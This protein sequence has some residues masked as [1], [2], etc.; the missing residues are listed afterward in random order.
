MTFLKVVLLK[1]KNKSSNYWI[2]AGLRIFVRLLGTLT[3]IY[4]L[5][6]IDKLFNFNSKNL[7][8][9]LSTT[10]YLLFFVFLDWYIKTSLNNDLRNNALR[11]LNILKWIPFGFA[12]VLVYLSFQFNS[13]SWSQKIVENIIYSYTKVWSIVFIPNLSF[14]IITI[15]IF[16]T[17]AILSRNK[18]LREENDLTI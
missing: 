5:T 13:F 3:M 8:D 12:V 15:L 9:F 17:S 2:I 10:F 1:L 4:W 11:W 16:Y 7:Y 18:S 6:V 14:I